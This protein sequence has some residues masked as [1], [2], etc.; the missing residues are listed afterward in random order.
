M[1]ECRSRVA[2]SKARISRKPR[3]P[4]TWVAQ[5]ERTEE[6]E[7]TEASGANGAWRVLALSYPPETTCT[8]MM[9]AHVVHKNKERSVCPSVTQTWRHTSYKAARRF[10]TL[11][12][13]S[14]MDTSSTEPYKLPVDA[15]WLSEY[16]S[17][18]YPAQTHLEQLRAA[19]QAWANH[20][21][22]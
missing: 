6:T 4:S 2:T 15:V 12:I 10:I 11:S 20:W 7:Q 1:Y 14:D 18:D 8:L 17:S 22:F 13:R 3:E 16:L 19:L 21:L 9:N 5:M